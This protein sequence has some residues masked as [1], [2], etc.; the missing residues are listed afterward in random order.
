[1]ASDCRDRA[2]QLP[3]REANSIDSMHSDQSRKLFLTN[4]LL[5]RA[6]IMIV[7]SKTM[8]FSIQYSVPVYYPLLNCVYLSFE[9]LVVS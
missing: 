9:L 7:K 3:Y 8:P 6:I 4:L 1:M 2:G 5:Q